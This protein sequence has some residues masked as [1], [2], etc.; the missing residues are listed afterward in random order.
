MSHPREDASSDDGFE[1]V[2][3]E[4]DWYD[5]PRSGVADIDAAPHYFRAVNDSPRQ[6]ENDEYFVWPAGQAALAGERER[7]DVFVERFE[8][9]NSGNAIPVSDID[10]RHDELTRRL[11]PH[12]TVPD[13]ARRMKAEWR[14][15]PTQ[16]MPYHPDGP[17]YR[18]KWRPV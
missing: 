2:H 17:S 13:G 15:R 10:R 9:V 3:I 8:R 14:P 5:G 1:P 7:W 12:R 11:E 18:A 6:G 16:T 4:L